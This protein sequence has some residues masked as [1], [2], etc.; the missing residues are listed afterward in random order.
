MQFLNL[1]A[2]Q[3]DIALEGKP[4]NFAHIRALLDANPPEPGALVVLPETFACGFSM[5]LAITRQSA[6]CATCTGAT[7]SREL[8]KSARF[9]TRRSVRSPLRTYSK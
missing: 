3:T 7:A 5:N 8:G 2:V 6:R 9:R 1:F 4:A